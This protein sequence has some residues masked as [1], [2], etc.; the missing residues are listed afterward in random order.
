MIFSMPISLTAA[1]IVS[2]R[3]G[4]FHPMTSCSRLPGHP[5]HGVNA[6]CSYEKGIYPGSVCCS[7]L[8]RHHA[9]ADHSL[10]SAT[11]GQHCS[12]HCPQRHD[13]G[14]KRCIDRM[15]EA[16]RCQKSAWQGT[17]AV[18]L[19]LQETDDEKELAVDAS[20]MSTPEPWRPRNDF[21]LTSMA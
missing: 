13:Q 21:E 17:Q 7:I 8:C 12:R 20:A 2:C 3:P 10:A 1:E 16:G 14:A 11:S 4:G 9:C 5:N 19:V 6:G 15:L 18:P